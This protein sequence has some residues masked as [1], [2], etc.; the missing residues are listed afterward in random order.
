MRHNPANRNG[1]EHEHLSVTIDRIL[2]YLGENLAPDIFQWLRKDAVHYPE[3][4][5]DTLQNIDKTR[6]NKGRLSKQEC[7]DLFDNLAQTHE[8]FTLIDSVVDDYLLDR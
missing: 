5:E 1:A 7:W 8:S 4:I 6:F 2:A 3:L